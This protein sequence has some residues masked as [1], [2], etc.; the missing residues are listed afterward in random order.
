ME[1]EGDSECLVRQGSDASE[2]TDVR[3]R[4]ARVWET[5][6]HCHFN[7]DFRFN[8]Q[9]TAM[10]FTPRRTIGGRAWLSLRLP[11]DDQEKALTAWGNTSLGMLLYWSHSNKQQAGRGSIGKSALAAL[12]AI[13]VTALSHERLQ[14]AVDIFEDLK[15][16][17]MRPVNEIT[18]DTVRQELDERFAVEVL[19]LPTHVASVTGE[20][21]ILRA[22]LA[23]EPSVRGSKST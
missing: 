21:G 22:K 16:R 13:D 19:G 17:S 14:A 3:D 12:A 5:A 15:S 8:S 4:V 10:Q 7:R 9:S 18:A 2:E 6:S 20:L 11:A 1:F 23:S